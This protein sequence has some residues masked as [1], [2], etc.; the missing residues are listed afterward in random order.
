MDWT[1]LWISLKTGFC[2]TLFAFVLALFFA[3]LIFG[4]HNH[5][6]KAVIDGIFMLPLI[7]PPTVVGFLLLLFFGWNSPTGLLL[8]NMGIRIIFTWEATVIASA[9]VAFPLIYQIIRA[10]FEQIDTS[11]LNAGRTLGLSEWTIFRHIMLPAARPGCIAG[12]ILGF[13]RAMGEF[14]ATLMIAGNI[15]GKTRTIPLAIWCETEGNN[16][17]AAAVWVTLLIIVSFLVIIPLNMYQK[18]P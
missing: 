13:A 7:L 10:S 2:A 8:R 12:M 17:T 16:M 9:V 18:R 3:K 5:K 14:G 11:L 6:L 1:P 4:L 15:P